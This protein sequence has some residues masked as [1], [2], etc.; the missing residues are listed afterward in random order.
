MKVYSG[1]NLFCQ[2]SFYHG[3]T[4]FPLSGKNLP[5]LVC[6]DT[7]YRQITL[8]MRNNNKGQLVCYGQELELLNNLI[9]AVDTFAVNRF[10]V[11]LMLHSLWKQRMIW[12]VSAQFQLPRGFIQQLL[13]SAASF[14]AC[15]NHFCQVRV[16]VG[17]H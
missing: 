4:V 6:I 3:K 7:I 14:A 11:T 2:S 15:I 13:T 5:I 9:Q 12:H 1:K 10:Y 8:L 17:L 16:L